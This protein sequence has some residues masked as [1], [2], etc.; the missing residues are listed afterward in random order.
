MSV[1]ARS[2]VQGA[3]FR[4][5]AASTTMGMLVVPVMLKLKRSACT[6]SLCDCGFQRAVGRPP[7][8]GPQPVVP[9]R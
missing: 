7:K 9:G 8:V 2:K 3:L 6:P 1:Q 4:L 5:V